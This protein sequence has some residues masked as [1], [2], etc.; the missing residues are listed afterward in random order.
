[1]KINQNSLPRRTRYN[2]RD[3]LENVKLFNVF[4]FSFIQIKENTILDK[5]NKNASDHFNEKVNLFIKINK[6]C[7]RK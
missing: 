7:L 2:N 1:M 6:I 5:K 4:F 3:V